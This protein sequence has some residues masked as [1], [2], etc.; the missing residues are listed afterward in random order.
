MILAVQCFGSLWETIWGLQKFTMYSVTLEMF[1]VLSWRNS[2]CTS[3]SGQNNLQPLLLL[4]W[5]TIFSEAIFCPSE[6]VLK[7]LNAG[8][9][10]KENTVNASTMTLLSIGTFIAIQV[11]P[12]SLD[13]HKPTFSDPS[14]FFYEK[15]NLQVKLPQRYLFPIWLCWA[16]SHPP[17]IKRKEHGLGPLQERRR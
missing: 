17:A 4:I 6:S 1:L 15:R 16:C 2:R 5:I 10:L 14:C 12:T 9:P 7:I 3:S 11:H 13:Y 8:S